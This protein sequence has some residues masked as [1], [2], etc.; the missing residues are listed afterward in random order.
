MPL[1]PLLRLAFAGSFSFA[2]AAAVG[3][4][5]DS[6]PGGGPAPAGGQ[7]ELPPLAPE[8]TT[9][10]VEW[11]PN[12]KIVEDAEALLVDETETDG[13]FTY[14]F[15]G[16]AAAVESLAPGDV[17]VLS[18]LAYRKVVSVERVDDQVILHATRTKLT[19]AIEKGTIDWKR[20]F[21]FANP[22]VLEK[23]SFGLEGGTL[24]PLDITTGLSWEG[25]VKDFDVSISLTPSAGRLDI[26]VSASKSVGGEKR[27]AVFGEGH[28]E[29]FQSEGHIELDSS[30]L[31]DLRYGQNEVR[32]QIKIT[33]AAANAG[34]SQ[35]LLSIP[36]RIQIPVQVGPVPLMVKLGA[37]VNVTAEL[38]AMP[39][40]AEAEVTIAFTSNQGFN[41]AG[42][43]A[44]LTSTGQ[45][46]NESLEIH[47]GGSASTLA[48]G[49]SACVEAPRVEVGFRGEF[50]S[51]GITQ[52]N[53]AS[54][55]FTFDP[56]CQQ[57]NASIVGKGLASLGF[58]GVT[59]ASADV[60]LYSKRDSRSN[61]QCD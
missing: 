58:F 48:A 41:V 24:R 4:S 35:D 44:G 7:G 21:D 11:K 42:G 33:A 43:A 56:A 46:T 15:R 6:A 53:C 40:S 20:S 45:L 28:L 30:G 2:L 34:A 32:G 27:I 19:D 52:N 25:K 10:E 14:R 50:A 22:G 54:T 3:C 13:A 39:A 26:R 59:L 5:S 47:G 57:V 23:A 16:D 29:R 8:E 18:G 51:I 31:V 9:F 55:V 38:Q 61:G 49:M 60:E 1:R 37:N 36:L 17:A 12:A